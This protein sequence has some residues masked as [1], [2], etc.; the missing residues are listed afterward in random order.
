M[1]PLSTKT[2]TERRA[3]LSKR[4]I[5]YPAGRCQRAGIPCGSVP[6]TLDPNR[7]VEAVRRIH[8]QKLVV[9]LSVDAVDTGLRLGVRVAGL[10][11]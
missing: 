9:H 7:P 3:D 11:R 4:T 8:E 2:A 10:P 5:Q 1:S 6:A